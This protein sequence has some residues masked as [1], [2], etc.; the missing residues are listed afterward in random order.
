MNLKLMAMP[1]EELDSIHSATLEVLNEVGVKFPDGTA[2][3]AL[4]DVGAEIDYNKMVAR[5]PEQAIIEALKH[6]PNKITLGARDPKHDAHL[7]D[8]HV[9]FMPSGIGVYIYDLETGVRRK[10]T[11]EDTVNV[12]K[13][14]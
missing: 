12:S 7:E 2:L 13:I 5:I 6:T 3:K 9:H 4:E 14:V 1:R 8:G 11:R 10:A